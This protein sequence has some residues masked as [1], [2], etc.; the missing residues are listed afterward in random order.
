[1]LGLGLQATL[2]P[3]GSGQIHPVQDGLVLADNFRL[4]PVNDNLGLEFPAEGTSVFNG[5]SDYIDTGIDIDNTQ[6][7]TFGAWVYRGDNSTTRTIAGDG[8]PTSGEAGF[9]LITTAATTD[10]YISYGTSTRTASSVLPVLNEWYYLT[11]SFASGVI[12]V[13]I[14]GSN[15]YNSTYVNTYPQHDRSIFVGCR[16]NQNSPYNAIQ[17]WDGNLANVAIWNRAL[18]SDEINSVMWKNYNQVT[19]SERVGLQAWYAL[20]SYYTDWVAYATSQGATI[21][22]ET[23]ANNALNA[24][25]LL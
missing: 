5:T 23:C 3:Q 15:V 22:G 10:L 21:E 16:R 20:S 13:Y 19:N 1:M 24:L 6:S 18:T 25:D 4:S 7:M 2:K 9:S 17:F 14:N 8:Y 11:A 12:K